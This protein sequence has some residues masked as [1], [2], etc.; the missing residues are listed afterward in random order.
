MYIQ[1][2]SQVNHLFVLSFLCCQLFCRSL[3]AADNIKLVS[4]ALASDDKATF[5]AGLK[6]VYRL[7]ARERI[8]GLRAGWLRSLEEHN[9]FQEIAD[10]TY[11]TIQAYPGY[12]ADLVFEFKTR[13]G[14]LR[15]LN[16]KD[17]ALAEAQRLYRVCACRDLSTAALLVDESLRDVGRIDDATQFRISQVA[18]CRGASSNSSSALRIG[19][20]AQNY[21]RAV[22]EV[23]SGLSAANR[24]LICDR[25][26]EAEVAF[27]QL[28]QVAKTWPERV[29]ALEGVA[30]SFRAQDGGIGRSNAFLRSIVISILPQRASEDGDKVQQSSTQ[31]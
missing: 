19:P 17:D 14:A 21:E 1:R 31:Q 6:A 27:R 5:E 8:D 2:S 7:N 28:L 15:R 12:T 22:N 16:R 10:L 29:A 3:S 13:I 24:L 18:D 25:A 11:S 26:I 4:D 9:R 20:S 23:E 30:R